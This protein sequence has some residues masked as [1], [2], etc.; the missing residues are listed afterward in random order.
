MGA[1]ADG[2]S[3][4]IDR[5]VILRRRMC[6]TSE[7]HVPMGQ[8]YT[9]VLVDS[10]AELGLGWVTE[11]FPAV[12]V[13]S[14]RRGTDTY[15]AAC[16]V[17][18]FDMRSGLMVTFTGRASDIDRASAERRAMESVLASAG[19]VYTGRFEEFR[20]LDIGDSEYCSNVRML[21]PD[22]PYVCI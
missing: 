13:P 15:S 21:S 6:Q 10:L 22:V 20:Y 4:F 14:C 12:R 7:S 8:G 9:D 18:I 17:E 1:D 19:M 5:F 2:R 3:D 11:T 16:L